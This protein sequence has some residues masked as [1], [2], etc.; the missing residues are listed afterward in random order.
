MHF[1]TAYEEEAP[2]AMS[3]P[4]QDVSLDFE[5]AVTPADA[6]AYVVT[7]PTFRRPDHLVATLKSLVVQ[8]PG[9][10]FAIIVMEND[11]DGLAGARAA[12]AFLQTAPVSARIVLAHRRGNCHAYNA[13]WTDALAAYP[14][15]EA[16]AVID[17]DELAQPD[18]L[19]RL[20]SQQKESG[21]DMVG[22]PQVPHFETGSWEKSARHPVFTAHYGTN[23]PV[24]ILYSSGN[25]LIR[26][27]VLDAMPRPF[28]DPLFNFIG[29]GD[30]DFY[31]RAREKGFRF[32]WAADAAVTETIPARRTEWDWIHAR[33][34]RNGAISAMLDHRAAPGL[35][36]RA[37]TLA[38]SIA[39]L[40][41][42]AP[43]GLVMWRRT[44]LPSA[45]LYH[46]QVALGRL[47]AEVG[48]VGEQYRNP[49]KN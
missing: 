46:G 4:D 16:L 1:V 32:A 44:G 3:E 15:F 26:R 23:G 31:R 34:L 2:R 9:K 5:R 42:A 22:G 35:F 29:G 12:R 14:N 10:P 28:L 6:I 7:L 17:D 11:T 37:R 33:S 30:S 49:E 38:K 19:F 47:M 39:L 20:V 48:R 18:W 41:A 43:R 27:A 24:P 36:G 40:A 25:V 45:S 21:A 8:N 13:G